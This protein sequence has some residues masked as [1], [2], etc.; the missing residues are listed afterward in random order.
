MKGG[1]SCV[2]VCASSG[3]SVCVRR[4]V[5]VRSTHTDAR[6]RHKRL[7]WAKERGV[8]S[9]RDLKYKYFWDLKYRHLRDQHT[10]TRCNTLQHTATYCN[11]L[12]YRH[13]WDLK[14]RHLWLLVTRGA[15]R[16]LCLRDL[17]TP[18]RATHCN[19]LQHTATHCNTLQHTATHC[20]TLQHT[21]THCNTLQHTAT[22]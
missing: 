22:H 2:C 15:K 6:T 16:G 5:C 13:L 10:A 14:Y 21:A 20:N 9:S 12:K 19:T 11:T 1:V 3:A 8:S 17:L 7:E 4:S 18:V